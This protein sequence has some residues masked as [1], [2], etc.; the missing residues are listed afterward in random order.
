MFFWS[1]FPF[2]RITIAFCLGI[3]TSVFLAGYQELAFVCITI[4][5]LFLVGSVFFNPIIFLKFNWIFGVTLILLSFSFGYARLFVESQPSS[6]IPTQ[7]ISAYQ[8]LVISQPIQKGNFYKAVVEISKVKDFVWRPLTYR[9]NLYVRTDSA[10]YNYGDNILVQG[11]PTELNPPQNP[12][13]FNY[14]RYLSFLSI[15]QQH[16]LEPASL[17][18]ISSGN[19]NVLIATSLK[20][21]NRFSRL[22]DEYITEPKEAAIAKALLLGN[23]SELDDEIINTYAA[24]GAMHVLAVSGLHVGIIYGIILWLFSLLPT[25]YQKK[26]LIAA[27]SIPLLWGYAFITGL[28]PSVLRA[29][30]LFSIM[31]TGSSFNRR[32]NM[33]NLLAVSAFILLVFKPYLLMQVGFQLS[34]VAVLGI[35]FLYPQIRKLWMPPYRFSLF[36]WDIISISIAAQIATL[37]LSILYF[38][39]FP[40]YFLISNLLVIPAATLIV[41]VGIAFFTLSYFTLITQ[42]LGWLLGSII[43]VVNYVL[44]FIYGL[45]W[46]NWDNIYLNVS[47]TWVLYL[48]IAFLFLF[49]VYKNTYWAKWASI[50][51]IFF[52]VLVGYRWIQN[53]QQKQIIA[54]KVSKHYAIDLIQSGQLLSVMDT[55]LMNKPDKIHFHIKPNR[56]LIG[57]KESNLSEIAMRTT[58]FGTA[59]VWNG[60]SILIVNKYVEDE[61]PFDIV[62]SKQNPQRLYFRGQP[63]PVSSINQQ[64]LLTIEL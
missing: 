8:G 57:A 5:S 32:T 4:G 10:L 3:I 55:V 19:G 15:Y 36:F 6:T 7:K 64:G 1:Q 18:V 54:Y 49:A 12:D 31:A 22:L 16:F 34:Y 39:R 52:S 26:W 35:I 33:V 24:S 9:I 53:N 25:H 20:L 23:K 40:P 30:T 51:M 43:G 2:V 42:W 21:R 47:Q 63:L 46:S 28:S 37:P 45:P 44:T 48:L 59:L 13:E 27:I 58:N 41:G 17:Q 29:V 50:T 62:F 11:S 60:I 14:K 38:H 61:Y 56:L